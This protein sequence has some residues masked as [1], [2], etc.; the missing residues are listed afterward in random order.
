MAIKKSILK[1]VKDTLSLSLSV[2]DCYSYADFYYHRPLFSALLLQN[3][4]DD[5]VTDL[6]VRL[7]DD[8]GLVV[9]TEKKIDEIPY[10]SSV[11]LESD[12]LLSPT[13]LSAVAVPTV[14]TLT[15]G[16]YLENNLIAEDSVTFTALPFQYA[17]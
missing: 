1:T 8:C 17:E 4:G 13:A 11:E 3:T 14:V 5:S 10:Q 15:V 16:M 12:A 2:R 6:T 7:H 9:M